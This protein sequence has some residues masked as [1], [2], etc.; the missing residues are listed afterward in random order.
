MALSVQVEVCGERETLLDNLILE[1]DEHAEGE[2]APKG[3]RLEK[4]KRLAAAEEDLRN[5][6]LHR[7]VRGRGE[8]AG[9]TAEVEADNRSQV[10]ASRASPGEG[11]NPSVGKKRR[12]INYESDEDTTEA[13]VR[14]IWS[15]E[16]I[17]TVSGWSWKREYMN[18]KRDL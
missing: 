9:H 6:A 11:R 4:E 3:Q 5:I 14:G 18:S 12:R 7:T 17:R 2:R 8:T 1:M 10:T 13:V 15:C 16:G